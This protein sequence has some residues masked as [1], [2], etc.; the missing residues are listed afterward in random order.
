MHTGHNSV[1]FPNSW[2]S[3]CVCVV[4]ITFSKII[5]I[6]IIIIEIDILLYILLLNMFILL[7]LIT[8]TNIIIHKITHCPFLVPFT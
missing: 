3:V 4:E 1:H 6:I 8:Y 7:Y 2:N 5:T